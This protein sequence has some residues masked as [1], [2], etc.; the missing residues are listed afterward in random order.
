[1]PRPTTPAHDHQLAKDV[2]VFRWED[3]T[4]HLVGGSGRGAGWANNVDVVQ[5][6]SPY[7]HKAWRSGNPVTVKSKPGMPTRIAGPYW[8]EQA[9]LVPVGHEHLV[10]FGGPRIASHPS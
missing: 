9:I 5:T 6:D 4:F 10:V 2:L 1:M 8:A 3:D 7:M